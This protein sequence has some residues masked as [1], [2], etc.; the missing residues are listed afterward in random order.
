[1]SLYGNE[2]AADR[3]AYFKTELNL[4][5]PFREGNGRTIRIFIHAFAF[6]RGV[7]WQYENMDREAY[8]DDSIYHYY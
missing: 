3:L 5:H 1:M 2:E 7:T 6:S 8:M 4:L